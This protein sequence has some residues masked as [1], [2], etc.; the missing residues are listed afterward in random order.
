MIDTSN[1]IGISNMLSPHHH[2]VEIVAISNSRKGVE[3]EATIRINN[4]L[5]IIH[6]NINRHCIITRWEGWFIDFKSSTEHM[7]CY[8]IPVVTTDVHDV[9][10]QVMQVQEP[11]VPTAMTAADVGDSDDDDS[12]G[13]GLGIALF[14]HI[15]VGF[16][17]TRRP[18]V[19]VDRLCHRVAGMAS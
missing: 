14:C 12:A 3:E 16:V 9:E 18:I 2:H 19:R 17:A 6:G 8:Y 10:S 1:K 15:L 4:N 13:K 5:G 11:K 7:A